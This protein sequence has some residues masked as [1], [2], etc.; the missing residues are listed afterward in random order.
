M[1][2]TSRGGQKKNF[3]Q[4]ALVGFDGIQ[5]VMRFTRVKGLF[6]KLRGAISMK[7]KYGGHH[8]GCHKPAY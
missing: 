1:L 6:I 4:I 5:G 2:G 8:F 7:P 3:Q